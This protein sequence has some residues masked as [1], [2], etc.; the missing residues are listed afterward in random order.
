MKIRCLFAIFIAV[1]M[2]FLPFMNQGETSVSNATVHA[3]SIGWRKVN[4]TWYYY[5]A[6]GVKQVGWLKLNS[7]Y[8]YF[9]KSG[10][11]KT[12]WLKEGST[13]YYLKPSGAM[14]TGW[15]KDG[16]T[17][18]YFNKSGA[19]KTGWL[20]EGST[21]YYLKPS[22]AMATG[23][24]KNGN[25]YYYFNKSGAM[26]T[27]WLKEGSKRYYLKPSGAMAIG[28]EKINNVW[29]YFYNSGVMATNTVI[30]GWSID[31]NG[32]GTPDNE[33]GVGTPDNE[34]GGGAPDKYTHSKIHFINT[35]RS[36]CTLIENNGR[37]ALIDAGNIDDDTKVKAYLDAQGVKTLDYLI[38][39]HYHE[40]HIGAADTVIT[41]FDVKTILVHNGILNSIVNQK[42]YRD[43]I[44][45]LASKGLT[46]SVPLEGSKFSLG[47]GTFTMMNTKGG[48]SDE[49]NNSLVTLYENG[50]DR[51]LFMADAEHAVEKT[52]SVGKVDL[53]KVGHHGS[54]RGSSATFINQISP[55]YAVIMVGQNPSGYPHAETLNEFKE[56]NIP[57]YRTDENG[58]I[59]FTSTGA[60]VTTNSKPGSYTPGPQS[61]TKLIDIKSLLN[62]EATFELAA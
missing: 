46:T 5:N 20:K 36:D 4:G 15:A 19:M 16:N 29:Y 11:M 13:W 17:Y 42:Y 56:T 58:T 26:K 1:I 31:E 44:N 24:V 27:G 22:G 32:V 23:W 6:S 60:G 51:L 40:D 14:A 49:N 12:G 45:A 3:Q 47:N 57:V 39:T 43:F 38:L 35:G 48:Y 41:N 9:N 61:L 8:Y 18:Y 28:W 7:T 10:A 37:Y 33:N 2:C 21:W 54:N 34:N 25:T 50:N 55:K 53:L 30:D 59:I 52:L 62:E